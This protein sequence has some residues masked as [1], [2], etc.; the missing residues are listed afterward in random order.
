MWN[1][2]SYLTATKRLYLSNMNHKSAFFIKTIARKLKLLLMALLF[3]FLIT[4]IYASAQSNITMSKDANAMRTKAQQLNSSSDART[5]AAV[6][7]MRRILTEKR[8]GNR[9]FSKDFNTIPGDKKRK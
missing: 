9:G 4:P 2:E 8:H 3:L 1:N 5:R 7:R 6:E